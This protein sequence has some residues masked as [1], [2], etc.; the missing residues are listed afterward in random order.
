M[1]QPRI[2]LSAVGFGRLD[3]AVEVSTGR[4]A[5]G[6]AAEQPILS[7]D[8]KRADCTLCSVIVNR[9]VAMLDVAFQLAPVAGQITDGFTQRVLAGDLGLCLLHPDLQLSQHRQAM[10]QAAQFAVII[11][12]VLQITLD[13][14]ELVD[15]VQRDICPAGLAL[16]LY[17]LRVN[18]LTS[19]MRPATQT[20]D[21]L[22]RSQ[23]VIAGVLEKTKS[24]ISLS[25][26]KAPGVKPI[27]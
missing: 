14:V 8:H 27:E 3:Q 25:S 21:T 26:I 5:F 22:L 7:A 1:A 13:S 4:C 12:R 9:Q 11:V 16:G 24:Y 19:C 10:L 15:Q 20:F 18:E 6:R 23:F 17:F 2:R